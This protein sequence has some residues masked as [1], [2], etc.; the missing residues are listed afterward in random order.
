MSAELSPAFTPESAAQA[1]LTP[2]RLKPV[3]AFAEGAAH[4]TVPTPAGTVALHTVGEGPRVL[5]LHGWEGQASDMS[6]FV[7]P[8]LGAG[9][10]VIAMDLPA[11]GASEGR[12]TSIPQAAVALKAVGEQLGP[13]HAV[14]AHSL[15]CPVLCEAMHA[16]LD[17][18]RAVLVSGPANFDAYVLAAGS[19]MGLDAPGANRMLALLT[20][21]LGISP[22]EVSVPARAVGFTQP[23]LFIHSADDAVVP[24][25][26]SVANAAAWKG[27]QHL[28]VE[29]LGHRRILRDAS[30]IA[31]AVA[32]VTA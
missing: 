8:L 2:R 21:R 7:A 28:R 4:R 13:L 20:E 17:V 12:Q 16:G 11:H 6:A 27:A 26:E 24:F 29:G 9:M 22:R 5:V 31:A 3:E 32:H 18:R 1:F 19:A 23:A 14:I 10:Q 25:A 30:V 15:G